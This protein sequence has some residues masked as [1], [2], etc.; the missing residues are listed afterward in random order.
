[1]IIEIKKIGKMFEIKRIF[2][3]SIVVRYAKSNNINERVNMLCQGV[4]NV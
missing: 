1:M 2:N 4:F 3:Q